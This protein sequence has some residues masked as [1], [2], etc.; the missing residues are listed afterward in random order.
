MIL[1]LCEAGEGITFKIR[2]GTWVRKERLAQYGNDRHIGYFTG[3][4]HM[5]IYAH[6]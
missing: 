6:K 2:R 3:I 1:R 5:H 4:I